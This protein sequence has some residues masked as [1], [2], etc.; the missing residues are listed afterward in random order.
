MPVPPPLHIP[1]KQSFSVRFLTLTKI[2]NWNPFLFFS[3]PLSNSEGSLSLSKRT[4]RLGGLLGFF[5][6][7]F[8]SSCKYWER[9][10]CFFFKEEKV[11]EEKQYKAIFFLKIIILIETKEK[12]LEKREKN[13]FEEKR[14]LER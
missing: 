3:F 4:E 7:V 9:G 10:F 6:V 5:F 13:F 8:F 14:T 12:D 2:F 11:E 1:F